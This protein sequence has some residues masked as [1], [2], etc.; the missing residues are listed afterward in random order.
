M[1]QHAHGTA[2][3]SIPRACTQLHRGQARLRARV[4]VRLKPP[5]PR[6]PPRPAPACSC[7]NRLVGAEVRVGN[8]PITSGISSTAVALNALVW[9]Q[10]ALPLADVGMVFTVQLASPVAGRWV[11]LQNKNPQTTGTTNDAI[12][13]V[14]NVAEV[15]TAACAR[16]RFEGRA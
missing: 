11:T 10:P 8:T 6:A 3:P 12:P 15:G 16:A 5:K 7:G 14:L 1:D 9:T 2:S 13:Y 4:C